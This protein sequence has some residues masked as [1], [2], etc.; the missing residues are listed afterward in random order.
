MRPSV[1]YKNVLYSK[2]K[3]NNNI[4]RVKWLGSYYW[5][6]FTNW[7]RNLGND[8]DDA[9]VKFT[10]IQHLL[11][12]CTAISWYMYKNISG[13]TLWEKSQRKEPPGD[14]ILFPSAVRCFHHQ[15]ATQGSAKPNNF[16]YCYCVYS[17]KR[18]RMSF[19]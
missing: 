15:V 8:K 6:P 3:Y 12:A 1:Y 17:K 2:K 19:L 11:L 16:K 10:K 18:I 7:R 4:K 5:N 9:I 13:H 14:Q